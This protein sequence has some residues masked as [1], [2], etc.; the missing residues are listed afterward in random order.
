LLQ[1]ADFQ[2]GRLPKRSMVK[3]T[4]MFTIHSSLVLKRICVLKR[5]KTEAVLEK[6]RQLFSSS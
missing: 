5:A 1:D 4:K 6:I 2:A 3:P